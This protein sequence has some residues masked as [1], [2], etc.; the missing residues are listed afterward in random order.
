MKWNS[1]M[2]LKLICRTSHSLP[3]KLCRIANHAVPIPQLYYFHTVHRLKNKHDTH[4]TEK[5]HCTHLQGH[6]RAWNE[7]KYVKGTEA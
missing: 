5:Q 7:N 1:I 3:I 2:I 6:Q 4:F